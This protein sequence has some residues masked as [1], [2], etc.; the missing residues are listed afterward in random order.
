MQFARQHDAATHLNQNKETL[1]H[2]PK[3]KEIFPT[4]LCAVMHVTATE[5]EGEVDT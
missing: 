5:N 4:A 2:L 3:E 1:N